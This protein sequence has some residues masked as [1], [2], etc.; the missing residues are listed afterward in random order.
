MFSHLSPDLSPK[1]S[2]ALHEIVRAE[3]LTKIP[4]KLVF[5]TVE[6]VFLVPQA[7]LETRFHIFYKENLFSDLELTFIISDATS[8]A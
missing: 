3:Y 2:R 1:L 8:Y 7:T 6:P 4:V 5:L